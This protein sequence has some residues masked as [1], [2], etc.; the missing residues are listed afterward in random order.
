MSIRAIESTQATPNPIMEA[1]FAFGRTQVL[2]SAVELDLFTHIENGQHSAAEL[3]R[4]TQASERGLRMLLN[5]LAAQQYLTKSGDRYYLTEMAKAFLSKRSPTCMGGLVLHMKQIQPG[6]SR[7][8]EV[9]RSGKPPQLIEGNGDRGEFFAQ[10][11]DS[12]YALGAPSAEAVARRI[13]TGHHGS[14]LRV[15]DVGAGSGV[16]GF[17]FA[18]QN[19][20]VRV[21]VADWPKVIETVTKKFAKREGISDRVEYL[22]G[23]F[24]ETEFGEN[25]YDVVTLGHICHSEGAEHTQEMFARVRRA[26]KPDGT[27]VVADFLADEQRAEAE[28]PLMFALN[29]LVHTEQGDTFTWS[30]CRQWLAEA[31]FGDASLVEVPSNIAVFLARKREVAEQAA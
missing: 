2:V 16:W 3:A 29:M 19:P 13:L 31:G 26:L 30:E 15:L 25:C 18:K 17:A 24:R 9:V 27:I 23:D 6:W 28:F 11:V 22:P 1:V 5:V 14:E 7:L 4:V 8:T 12:L 21:T 20:R 10:F